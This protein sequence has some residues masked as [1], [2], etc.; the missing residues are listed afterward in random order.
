MF[1]QRHVVDDA[2]GFFASFKQLSGFIFLLFV[3]L[4]DRSLD[5]VKCTA[6]IHRCQVQ[7]CF[8]VFDCGTKVT[9][10]ITVNAGFVQLTKLL[11]FFL[12]KLLLLAKQGF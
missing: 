3:Q 10:F 6:G 12:N 8:K 2:E 4:L 7:C 11:L 9:L 1:R 5:Q